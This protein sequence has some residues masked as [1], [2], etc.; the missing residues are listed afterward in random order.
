M[1]E[2]PAVSVIM[3]VYN[4]ERYLS[5]AIRSIQSQSL[6]DFE[7]VIVDDGSEDRTPEILR[8]AQADSRIR[9]L[10]EPRL[11][12]A[13]ALNVAWTNARGTYIANLDADDIAYPS[14]LEKQ[15][16]FLRRHPEIGLLGT[17][18]KKVGEDDLDRRSE[19][20]VN[21]PLTDSELRRAMVRRNP[22]RHSSLMI[23]KSVL[24]D[25]G[26]YNERLRVA[27]DYEIQV[28]IACRYQVANLPDVLATQRVH[29]ASH[30]RGVPAVTRYKAAVKTRWLAWRCF[31]RRVEEL[32]YVL[33][34]TRI[35]RHSF[36][37]RFQQAVSVLRNLPDGVRK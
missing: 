23:P 16:G 7:F 10:S 2:S 35:L 28:R 5:E 31:S 15:L 30:F 21:P 36:G 4:G 8:E 29:G 12:R 11:G 25:V 37:L 20:V 14:R 3:T 6:S 24:E 34:P 22:F 27:I 19:G 13:R 32:P 18:W 17:A 9:V 26:G 1:T 33:S